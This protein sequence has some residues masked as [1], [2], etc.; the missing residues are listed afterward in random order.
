MLCRAAR[1]C[2]R[3]FEERGQ[4]FGLCSYVAETRLFVGQIKNLTAPVADNLSLLRAQL[5]DDWIVD[6]DRIRPEIGV[7]PDAIL[8]KLPS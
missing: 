5:E 7:R 8:R 6:V 2:C 4:T 1:R 3:S